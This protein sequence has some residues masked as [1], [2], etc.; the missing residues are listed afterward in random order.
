MSSDK[1]ENVRNTSGTCRVSYLDVL[2][3]SYLHNTVLASVRPQ[4]IL[5][6]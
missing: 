1:K 4:Y 5:F 2:Q 3:K 6:C